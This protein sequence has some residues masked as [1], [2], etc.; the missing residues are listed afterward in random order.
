MMV[1]GASTGAGGSGEDEDQRHRYADVGSASDS[2]HWLSSLLPC[3][4]SYAKI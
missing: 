2:Q 3:R 1:A 4:Q